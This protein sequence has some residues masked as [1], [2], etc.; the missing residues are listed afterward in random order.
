MNENQ[1]RVMKCP[2]LNELPLPQPGKSGWPWTEESPQLPDT[3]P[4]GIPWPKISIVTPSLNQGQFIEETIRSVLLQGY[5]NLEYIIIDGESTDGSVDIIKKYD[6]WISLWVSEPDNGQSNA[7]N[8]GFANA[9]GDLYAWINADDLYEPSTFSL[10]AANFL[11]NPD[12]VL[13]YGDCMNI[14]ESGKIFS[15]SKSTNY[16]RNRLIRYLPNYIA[17]P[18]AFFRSLAFDGLDESLHYA[19][20]YDL[21]IRLGER[22]SAIYLSKF[23]AKF[24]VH[25]CSKTFEGITSYWPEVRRISRCHGSEFWSPM[26]IKYLRDRFYL[27]RRSI[28]KNFKL[29]Q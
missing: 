15:I 20:D 13:I 18:T 2:S 4:D 24:R 3:L 12:A 11:K 1:Y 27:L 7:I 8:K 21:W 22:G 17:Q 16:N 25:K 26:Y 29:F 14:D 10:V 28:I 19:M 9:S 23:L 5:P 6:Q